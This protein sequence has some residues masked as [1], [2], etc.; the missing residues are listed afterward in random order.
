MM[1][2]TGDLRG[3]LPTGSGVGG[4]SG[5]RMT[6]KGKQPGNDK[7]TLHVLALEVKGGNSIRG[8]RTTATVKSLWDAQAGGETG[9]AQEEG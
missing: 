7:G 1:R 6:R 2:G 4:V 5:R 8:T 9:E 3:F